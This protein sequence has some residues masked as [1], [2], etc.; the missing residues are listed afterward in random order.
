MSPAFEAS[1]GPLAGCQCSSRRAKR[2][3]GHDFGTDELLTRT[4]SFAQ[5]RGHSL[6]ERGV[7]GRL[8][9]D[10]ALFA[11]IELRS[12]QAEWLDPLAVEDVFDGGLDRFENAADVAVALGIGDFRRSRGVDH[13][14]DVVV[15]LDQVDED[16][17]LNLQQEILL[18][19]L[20][21][22]VETI[23]DPLARGLGAELAFERRLQQVEPPAKLVAESLDGVEQTAD[24]DRSD[25]MRRRR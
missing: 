17:A 20:K 9:R 19:V 23:D 16:R 4:E 24:S 12:F 3:D 7:V 8:G 18:V 25:G 1:L 15:K 21:L 11:G 2:E 10:R 14:A 6:V 5:P 22:G 13:L